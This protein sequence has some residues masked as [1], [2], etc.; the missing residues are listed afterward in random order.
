LSYDQGFFSRQ[1][2]LL[3]KVDE[4]WEAIS[5]GQIRGLHHNIAEILGVPPHVL[6]LSSVSKGCICL[7][8]IVPSFMPDHLFPLTASQEK[9]LL[10]ANAFR[11]ECGEYIWLVRE[12]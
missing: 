7:E 4:I 2:P 5:L 9:A 6:Y 11:L 12:I 3:I 8:F 1:K 10:A